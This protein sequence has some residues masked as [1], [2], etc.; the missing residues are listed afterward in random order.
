M[1][2]CMNPRNP[3]ENGYDLASGDPLYYQLSAQRRRAKIIADTPDTRRARERTSRLPRVLFSI[4]V[5]QALI[6]LVNIGRSKMLSHLLGPDG[7]GVVSTIDQIV[8]AVVQLGGLSLQFTALKFMATAHSQGLVSFQR[9]YDNF[10][11]VM[12]VLSVSAAVVALLLMQ[13]DP[14]LFGKDLEK[15]QTLIRIAILGAPAAMMNVFFIHALAAAQ[16]PASSARLNLSFSLMAAAGSIAG[17]LASGMPGLYVTSV[18]ATVSVTAGSFYF[19]RR[20][21]GLQPMHTE[22]SAW[23]QLRQYP[24]LLTQSIQIYAAISAYSLTMLA[25]RYLV[26]SR[27][28]EVEAGW[29]QGSFG[30]ALSLGAVIGPMSN[31]YLTPLVNREATAASKMSA[32]NEFVRKAMLM[33]LLLSLP[34]VLFPQAFI[35][36]LYTSRF[37]PLAVTLLFFIAWQCLAQIV[38][39]YQQVLIGLQDVGYFSA[40]TCTGYGLAAIL[41]L[42]LVPHLGLKGAALALGAGAVLMGTAAAIRLR[43]RYSEGIP[44]DVMLLG[45]FC[46]TSLILPS[47]IPTSASEWSAI[48]IGI[49]AG[50]LVAVFTG[51]WFLIGEEDRA[52][53]TRL[54]RG[55]FRGTPASPE[56]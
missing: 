45:V 22:I 36:I 15:Y 4:I 35:T 43:V 44:T 53:V 1:P 39:V 3:V 10:L 24:D 41:S 11:G 13:Q 30:I 2:R 25:I 52:L 16:K 49:R 46:L 38:N 7:F 42:W 56:S 54:A 26:I 31:L 55:D 8:V 28:G 33:V 9:A 29:L 21:L 50:Y 37:H 48:G 19:M 32:A 5:I 12:M 20:A 40:T 17:V 27:L 23:T 6:I 51:V 47:Q 14:G 18:M 34:V